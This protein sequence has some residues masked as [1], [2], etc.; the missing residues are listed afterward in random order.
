MITQQGF[1]SLPLSWLGPKGDSATCPSHPDPASPPSSRDPELG[2]VLPGQHPCS[3]T[4]PSS[5]HGGTRQGAS[6]VPGAAA[7]LVLSGVTTLT[8]GP[9]RH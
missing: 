3:N 2:A 5:L 7:C 1:T 9:E 4:E 6:T 8:Y